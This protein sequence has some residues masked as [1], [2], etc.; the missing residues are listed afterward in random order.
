V[1]NVV[2]EFVR[3]FEEITGNEFEMVFASFIFVIAQT[4]RYDKAPFIF[5]KWF[6]I[7]H[8]FKIFKCG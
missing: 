5:L 2:K 3:L 7:P 4:L 1:D 8:R 6:L